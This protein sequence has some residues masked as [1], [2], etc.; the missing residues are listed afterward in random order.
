MNRILLSS[1]LAVIAASVSA[2]TFY[3]PGLPSTVH[4]GGVLFDVRNDATSDL[5]LTGRFHL[6]VDTL[7]DGVYRAYYRPT[8][9]VGSESTIAGW[10][11]WGEVSVMGAGQNNFTLADFGQY[12]T[13]DSG[14][15][16]G[17]AL[18]HVGGSTW[19]SGIGALG[20]R[21]GAGSFTDPTGNLTVTTG[22]AKGYADPD[23]PFVAT[24]FAP[25]TWSGELEFQAVPEPATVAML[26][27][28][29]LFFARR[30]TR[31]A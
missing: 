4:Y 22:A 5:L 16:I 21:G 25:R 17:I 24:T 29:L 27:G 2:Q 19:S 10:T 1:V 9:Y 8:T 18:F 13:L 30:R 14:G 26:A 7:G 23:D 31:K 12:L 28:G 15:S 3:G 20:Y 6:N 11:Q